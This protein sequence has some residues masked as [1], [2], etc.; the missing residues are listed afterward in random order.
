[1]SGAA[2]TGAV[3]IG[4]TKIAV[5]AVD[6]SGRVLARA[7][8][9]TAAA[10][11]FDAAMGRVAQLL[12]SVSAGGGIE[13]DG[14]GIGCTGPVDPI[15][16]EIGEVGFLPGWRGANPVKKLAERFHVDVAMEN[17]A[18]AA[19]LG[20]LQWGA[21]RGRRNLICVTIG[22]GIGGG[23]VL[24]GALYRGVGGAHPEIGH[25]VID[26]S[27][28]QCYCGA[29]GCWEVLASGP[30]IAAHARAALPSDDPQR[31][32]LTAAG[33]C[34]R[35]R[36]GDPLAQSEVARAGRYLGIGIA[37]LVSLFT[38]DAIVL[39][40]SVMESADL[41]MPTIRAVVRSQCTQVPADRTDIGLAALGNEAPLIGAAAVW[42]HRH[43]GDS[44]PC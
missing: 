27:G 21:G 14:I 2:A 23:I 22:T 17:D 4:G 9:P 39:S 26:D 30:A 25:H 42:R 40:G 36:R 7:D 44:R 41:F 13:L 35:A 33:L 32:G 6:A 31:E 11:G 38:P 15:R 12:G 29:R 10:E 5:A 20:E 16:G 3:D 18:D 8:T 1:M 34:A 43:R 24:N 37:N 19:V 28:P